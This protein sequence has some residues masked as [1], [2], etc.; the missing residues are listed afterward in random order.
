MHLICDILFYTEIKIIKTKA[1]DIS[2]PH[3]IATLPITMPYSQEKQ[4]GG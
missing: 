1:F 3:C 4:R 2:L